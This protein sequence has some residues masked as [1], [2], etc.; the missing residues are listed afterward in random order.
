MFYSGIPFI[1]NRS[2]MVHHN[3]GAKLGIFYQLKGVKKYLTCESYF[4]SKEKIY[5]KSKNSHV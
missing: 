1:Q 5:L 3:F 4:V 2:N